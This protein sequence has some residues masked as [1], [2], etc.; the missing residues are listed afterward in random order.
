MAM[1][2]RSRRGGGA[3]FQCLRAGGAVIPEGACLEG[4]GAAP[5]RAAVRG[6]ATGGAGDVH[7]DWN[8]GGET[9]PARTGCEST[10]RDELVQLGEKKERSQMRFIAR[11]ISCVVTLVFLSVPNSGAQSQT[12][13]AKD[14]VLS[15]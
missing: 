2:L 8:D 15:R 1:D 12:T 3:V 14:T 5:E 6:H 11:A 13:G 10:S 9:L 7:R 4:A